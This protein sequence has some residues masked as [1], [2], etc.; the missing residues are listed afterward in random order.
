MDLDLE[1]HVR[2]SHSLQSN[3]NN[4]QAH[5]QST[6]VSLSDLTQWKEQQLL[7]DTEFQATSSI[8]QKVLRIKGESLLLATAT[9]KPNLKRRKR[10]LATSYQWN[11]RGHDQRKLQALGGVDGH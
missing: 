2:S 3:T 6:T 1:Q 5:F 9:P 11:E 10:S 7:S 4:A 8:L